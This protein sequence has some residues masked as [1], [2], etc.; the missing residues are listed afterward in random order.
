MGYCA[1]NWKLDKNKSPPKSILNILPEQRGDR[2]ECHDSLGCSWA[3]ESPRVFTNWWGWSGW[4]HVGAGMGVWA[5]LQ[6][7][8]WGFWAFIVVASDF[9]PLLPA[10]VPPSITRSLSS[11]FGRAISYLL[12]IHV[13]Q[14]GLTTPPNSSDGHMT[15]RCAIEVMTDLEIGPWLSLAQQGLVPVLLLEL[16]W[17]RHACYSVVVANLGDVSL[18]PLAAIFATKWEE[19]DMS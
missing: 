7:R 18:L 4:R 13:V 17:K 16:L 12:L 5:I 11:S 14:R 2:S 10:P 1:W 15:L 3:W 19:P 9:A 8:S 6:H